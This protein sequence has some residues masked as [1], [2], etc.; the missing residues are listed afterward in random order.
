MEHLGTKR[1]ETERLIL[2]RFTLND[3]ESM[4]NNW[5]ND[6]EVYE[7]M[8]TPAHSDINATENVI[9]Q[10]IQNYQ[11]NEFYLW[12]IVLKD[13]NEPIGRISAVEKNDTIKMVHIGYVVGKKWWKKG[14]ASEALNRYIEYFF[15]DVGINRIEGK[16][17]IGNENSGKVMK[18]CGM[19]YE[20]L[21]R[22]EC[23][24]NKG[25]LDTVNY[26]ILAEDY[27]NDKNRI[28]GKIIT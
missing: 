1:L 8:T 10:W 28:K 16:H 18:K 22:Q 6:N 25:V 4:F 9:K 3:T 2:R 27:F 15:E 26:A 21:M 11:K 12:A 7:Y 17:V 5:A 24:C 14:I 13:I 20:G 23:L 19:K